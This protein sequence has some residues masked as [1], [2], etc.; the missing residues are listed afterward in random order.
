MACPYLAEVTMVFCRAFPVKK[1]LA[2]DRLSTAG[3][4]CSECFSACAVYRDFD[5]GAGASSSETAE[6]IHAAAAAG[7]NP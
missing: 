6:E 4:C 1:L 2:S 3:L 5:R 7:G